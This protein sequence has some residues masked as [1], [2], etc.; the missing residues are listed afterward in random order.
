MTDP[1]R[2]TFPDALT[3]RANP[4]VGVWNRLEGRPRSTDFDRALRAEVR[5]PLWMLT[6]Q[7]QLGEFE[8]AD[9]GSPV[10][11]TYALSTSGFGH[12]ATGD[13]SP[14]DLP[15][16][17]PLESLAERRAVPFRFGADPVGFDL[18][19][20][21]GHRWF[22]LI[23]GF[24]L[25]D[26]LFQDFRRQ[27]VKLYPIALPD[28]GD[29]DDAER[30]AHPEV[31]AT[32]QAL[33]G[34]H[35]DGYLLYQHIKHD[36]GKASDGISDLLHVHYRQLEDRGNA[37]VA[38]FDA[39]IDQPSGVAPATPDGQSAW[40]PQRLEH[41]FSV[42][43][44]NPDGSAKA[45]S[46][47]EFP[48][49]HLDWHAFSVDRTTTVAGDPPAPQHLY[50]TVFPAPVRYS[51]MPLPRW[52][53][54]EDGKTNF[55]AVNPDSTDLARLVF[56]E[57]ALVYSNDWYQLPCDLPAGTFATI[58]GLTV[59]D[60]F[61][62]KLWIT[63]ADAGPDADH[64]HWR[65]FG[66]STIVSPKDRTAVG[67]DTGLL[68]PPS[69]PK[70]SDGPLLEEIALIR[71][72]NANL[73]WG[74][75]QTVRTTTGESRRGAEVSAEDITFRA[76]FARTDQ[77]SPPRAAVK[78]VAMNSI[79]EQ[80]IPFTPVHVEG[81]DRSIR[82]QRAALP[83]VVDA[84]PI[85]PR[86]ALLREGLDQGKA[87]YLNEE[88]VPSAGTRLT[89][90]YRRTRWHNGHVVVWLAARRGVGRG[91]GSSGLAFDTLVDNP[92]QPPGASPEP[93]SPGPPDALD[94]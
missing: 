4:T 78:Y 36:H 42:S 74:V 92:A 15:P 20:A 6:R 22:K 54:I 45:L 43:T 90:S 80:W 60:V 11:A 88:E 68:V 82:L 83:S 86:T 85:R 5:D 69:V 73:V 27:Y 57:F 19:L 58:E 38:W 76:R 16:D 23:A 33:A 72:E 1:I 61:G 32:M 94:R 84:N 37:L 29:V 48:G 62:Q 46:A 3:D 13:G 49:G 70:V 9:A 56:L 31:W 44:S 26:V 65:M 40:D 30:V 25:D 71:D 2:L 35:L 21:I 63:A 91:E 28:P 89:V 67:A 7:W 41:T 47:P 50:R 75:E 87:Y 53:A 17:Q 34:R 18:R 79:P 93:G 10:T 77:P 55:A 39:L 12:F 24:L 81:D 66:L 64:E 14:L 52:W 59:T 51:G 8:G